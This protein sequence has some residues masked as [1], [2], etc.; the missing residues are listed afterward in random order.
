MPPESPVSLEVTGRT[1]TVYLDRPNSGNRVDERLAAEL[2]DAFDQVERD[3]TV[4]VAVLAGRGAA[5]CDGTEFPDPHIPRPTERLR[6]S[7]RITSFS[8]PLVAALNGTALDQGLE[9]ALACDFRV[10]ADGARLGLTQTLTGIIPWDGGTQRLPRLIGQGRAL[11]MIMTARTVDAR[12]ALALGLVDRVVDRNSVVEEAVG[13]ADTIAQ[14]GP[15]AVR[16]AKEAVRVG[17]DLSMA[18][19]MRL[20]ADLNILL[21]ST[22]DR[23]EG[24]RSFIEKRKPEYKGE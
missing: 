9:L 8:K 23:A 14:H 2:R 16:Y 15:I 20:E 21:Q 13:L 19:G 10:A 1:A 4:W 18:Q 12:E 7:D 24:I 3:D 17:Q 6:V 22:E 11:E 5:F